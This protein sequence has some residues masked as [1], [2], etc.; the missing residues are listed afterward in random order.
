MASGVIK[1]FNEQKGFGFIIEDDSRKE[2]FMHR[3]GLKERVAEGDLVA[4]EIK[5]DKKGLKA[6]NVKFL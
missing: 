3:S 2:I 5:A 6:N 4:F 1:F